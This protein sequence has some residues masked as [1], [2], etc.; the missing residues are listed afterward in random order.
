MEGGREGGR[1]REREGGREGRWHSSDDSRSE[2]HES[3]ESY[4]LVGEEKRVMSAKDFSS[5]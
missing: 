4:F 1:E 5:A 2:E 3:Y